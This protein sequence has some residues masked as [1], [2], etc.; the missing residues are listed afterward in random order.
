[1]V[2]S[3]AITRQNSLKLQLTGLQAL[4]SARMNVFIYRYVFPVTLLFH[5][6]RTIGVTVLAQ[7][8]SALKSK[9]FLCMAEYVASR[10]QRA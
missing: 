3:G 8:P 7:H 6:N 2:M 9:A 10:A 5:L 4:L 1:M